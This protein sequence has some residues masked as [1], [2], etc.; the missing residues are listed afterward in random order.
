MD[1][2]APVPG[3][4]DSVTLPAFNE[5]AADAFVDSFRSTL[6]GAQVICAG[7]R[8]SSLGDPFQVFAVGIAQPGLREDLDALRTALA[9]F[10]GGRRV[11]NFEESATADPTTLWDGETLARLRAVKAAVDPDDTIRSNHPLA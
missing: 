1:P 10:D 7:E 6:L 8:L 5:A 9:P 3:V 2:P 4:G 11:V